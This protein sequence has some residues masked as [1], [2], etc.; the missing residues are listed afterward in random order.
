[1]VCNNDQFYTVC[2]KDN[3]NTAFLNQIINYI[4]E[5][6]VFEY[7]YI[8]FN[9]QIFVYFEYANVNALFID[10]PI[11]HFKKHTCS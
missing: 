11:H 5:C 1:M 4:R 9:K 7:I 10:V 6:Y 3:K 8:N 2:E